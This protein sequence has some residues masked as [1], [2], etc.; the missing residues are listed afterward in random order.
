MDTYL[1]N[2]KPVNLKGTVFICNELCNLSFEYLDSSGMTLSNIN[3]RLLINYN[4]KSTIK[5]NGGESFGASSSPSIYTVAQI[6]IFAPPIHIIED[7]RQ[8]MELVITHQSA[9]NT[10][11]QHLCIFL[12]PSD[13][14]ADRNTLAWK[15][16]DKFANQLPQN[17]QS[18]VTVPN[19]VTWNAT[20]LLPDIS[21]RSFMTYNM[22]SKNNFVVFTQPINVPTAFYQNFIT[23][24]VTQAKYE[25]LTAIPIP[26][27][28]PPDV[29]IFAKKNVLEEPEKKPPTKDPNYDETN[30]G[31]PP[32]P[33]PSPPT[34]GTPTP[35]TPTPKPTNGNNDGVNGDNEPTGEGRF[36]TPMGTCPAPSGGMPWWG[37]LLIILA[38]L[39][40][41]AALWYF[42]NN[43][44]TWLTNIFTKGEPPA[45]PPGGAAS[46][47]AAIAFPSA[48]V[49][50]AAGAE[51]EM[52]SEYSYGNVS[53]ISNG[54]ENSNTE[55]ELAR[56]PYEEPVA[57]STAAMAAA[58]AS[59]KT[60]RISPPAISTSTTRPGLE[61]EVSG[62]EN[63]PSTE[64]SKVFKPNT[65]TTPPPPPNANNQEKALTTPPPIPANL[66][67]AAFPS[68]PT[69]SPVSST[70]FQ[71]VPTA[72][73]VS[74]TITSAAFPPVPTTSPVSS[75][76]T[77]PT[78]PPVPTSTPVLA[79]TSKNKNKPRPKLLKT[80]S[81]L[82][83]QIKIWKNRIN[84][85][86]TELKKTTDPKKI[87][88]I[89]QL[90]S[91]IQN[92][93]NYAELK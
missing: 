52:P 80:K 50:A 67:S 73:P 21:D 2:S 9:D 62:L 53:N 44:I 12:N 77:S 89:K 59:S 10:R 38:I 65:N 68:V 29:V 27:T 79:M 3:N 20:D 91:K 61:T 63:E 23:N 41:I 19:V 71:P 8:K 57:S 26:K 30:F 93:I 82:S 88:Q 24:I 90:M 34:N 86:S 72:T 22:D 42:R 81:A 58:A 43:I 4:S 6:T 49:G 7:Q 5:Y 25:Q 64:F 48:A 66:P 17:N 46:L 84:K 75:K 14:L 51:G 55:P 56:P 83:D 28:A 36:K 74:S 37:I 54:G 92:E 78:F 33:T 16:F 47:A 87:K 40:V 70:A 13:K 76:A 11:F 18:G 1:D 39:S 45:A 31:K 60:P 69:T 32:P 85:Y 15:L 35:P